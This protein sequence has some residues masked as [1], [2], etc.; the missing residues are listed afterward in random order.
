MAPD[1]VPRPAAEQDDKPLR[2]NSFVTA[3]AVTNENIHVRMISFAAIF[4]LP[5]FSAQAKRIFAQ[6]CV[7]S[8]DFAGIPI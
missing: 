1:P 6:E 4:A 3:P 2:I 7:K 8:F 5:S